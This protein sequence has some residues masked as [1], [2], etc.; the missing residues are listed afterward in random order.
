DESFDPGQAAQV[1]ASRGAAGPP[2]GILE[3]RETEAHQKWTNDRLALGF[4]LQERADDVLL[5][6]AVGGAEHALEGGLSRDFAA[7]AVDQA[8]LE[9]LR[10]HWLATL[11]RPRCAMQLLE[12][13]DR[14]GQDDGPANGV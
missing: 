6:D 3:H 10:H 14:G 5:L 1:G 4:E 13:S 8:L 7:M 9:C 12:L 11:S 2:L